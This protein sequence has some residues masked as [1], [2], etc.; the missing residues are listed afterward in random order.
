MASPSRFKNIPRGP[1]KWRE[2]DLTKAVKAAK[3]AGGVDRIEVTPSGHIQL[4]LAEQAPAP[5]PPSSALP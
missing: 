3:R 5:E 1:A 4:V 2:R